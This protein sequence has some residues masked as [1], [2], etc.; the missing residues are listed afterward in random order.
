[1]KVWTHTKKRQTLIYQR[2]N[3]YLTLSESGAFFSWVKIP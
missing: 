3:N 1:M 2:L